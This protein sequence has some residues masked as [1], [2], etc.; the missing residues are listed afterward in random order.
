MP[1]ASRDRSIRAPAGAAAN[2]DA[3]ALAEKES[4]VVLARLRPSLDTEFATQPNPTLCGPLQVPAALGRKPRQP[5]V[6]AKQQGV[7]ADSF[8]N[9]DAV[10]RVRGRRTDWPCK[11]LRL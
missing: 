8:A 1:G 6:C 7:D 11:P 3:V 4:G 9:L 5:L 10:R 2:L